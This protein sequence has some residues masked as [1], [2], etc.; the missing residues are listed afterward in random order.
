MQTW[1]FS[2]AFVCS[3][4]GVAAAFLMYL[5][6]TL[7]VAGRSRLELCVVASMF[8][9]VGLLRWGWVSAEPPEVMCLR[10]QLQALQALTVPM[11]VQASTRTAPPGLLAGPP[12]PEAYAT[13]VDDPMAAFGRFADGAPTQGPISSFG[14]NHGADPSGSLGNYAPLTTPPSRRAACARQCRELLEGFRASA[15][16]DPMWMRRFWLSIG[17]MSATGVLEAGV[18]NA[19]RA[20]GYIG[21]ATVSITDYDLLLRA[22]KSL[23]AVSVANGG[24]PARWAVEDSD[25][26][27]P[28]S[29]ARYATALPADYR[30]AAP[31][32]Y[33]NLRHQG[34]TTVRE[35]MM[36]TYTGYKGGAEWQAL[37]TTATQVDFV[38]GGVSDSQLQTLLATDDQLEVSLRHLAAATYEKRTGDRAGAAQMR[39]VAAPGSGVDIA[40]SWLVSDVTAHSKM[41]HTRAERVTAEQRR[42]TPMDPKGKEGPKGKGKGKDKNT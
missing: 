37:Y 9:G 23:E 27:L 33:R 8:L 21:Q 36:A 38:I 2:R 13:N 25:V 34:A 29:T 5:A 11:P 6:S 31:E 32:I 20:H 22:L 17:Q 41:E 14:Q 42:R 35:W 4:C 18:E 15:D 30:R 1:L 16:L 24:T 19:L 7:E 10:Q 28:S 40:P 26:N 39:A 12:I 3:V